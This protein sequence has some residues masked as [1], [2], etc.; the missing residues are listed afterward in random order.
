MAREA[1]ETDW[2][3]VIAKALA[4]LCI[5]QAGLQNETLVRQADFLQRFG[6]PRSEV[7]LILGTSEG[8]LGVMMRRKKKSRAKRATASLQPSKTKHRSSSRG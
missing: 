5:H 6:L 3:A 4:F 8:S 7:A 2:N 1:P